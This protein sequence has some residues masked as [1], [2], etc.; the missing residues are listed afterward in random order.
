MEGR[1]DD[2]FKFVSMPT[3]TFRHL[4]IGSHRVATLYFLANTKTLIS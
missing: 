4:P 3:P 2:I 1:E